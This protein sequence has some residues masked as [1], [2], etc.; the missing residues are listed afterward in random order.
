MTSFIGALLQ[1]RSWRLIQLYTPSIGS[2]A[3]HTA[4]LSCRGGRFTPL[5]L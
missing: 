4:R 3:S 2:G 5:F 1:R